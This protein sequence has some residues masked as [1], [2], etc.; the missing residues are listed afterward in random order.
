[1]I[2]RKDAMRIMRTTDERNRPVPFDIIYISANK[3]KKQ[4][5]RIVTLQNVVLTEMEKNLPRNI[6]TNDTPLNKNRKNPRH[7]LHG[8]KNLLVKE[9]GEIK[10]FHVILMTIFNGLEVIP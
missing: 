2:R 6:R 4:G 9:T 8:T 5:G 1:M 7:D 3:L 10:K